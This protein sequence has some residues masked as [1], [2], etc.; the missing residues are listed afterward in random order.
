MNLLN[1]IKRLEMKAKVGDVTFNFTDGSTATAT[2]RELENL[3]SHPQAIKQSR[4]YKVFK[5]KY[6]QGIIDTAGIVYDMIAFDPETVA[7]VW[8]DQT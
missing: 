4:L 5:S 3:W 2:Q 7:D 1:R 8:K 6:N